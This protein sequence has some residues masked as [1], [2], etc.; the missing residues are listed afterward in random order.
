MSTP[1]TQDIYVK[2]THE[3]YSTNVF[4][5]VRSACTHSAELAAK[6]QAEKLFGPSLID[7]AEVKEG[8]VYIRRFIATADPIKYA[9]CWANGL[10]ELGDAMPAD[11]LPV[12]KGPERALRAEL[13][14]SARHGLGESSGKLLVPGVPEAQHQGAARKALD[15]WLQWRATFVNGGKNSFGVEYHFP[16][17]A[18]AAA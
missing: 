15:E 4:R 9:W 18:E 3:G 12:A 17:P 14:V 13:E 5:N 7:V 6:R 11:A 10:V 2:Q 8:N 1:T 16:S